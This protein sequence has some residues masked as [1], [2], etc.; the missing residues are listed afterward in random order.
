[1]SARLRLV[2]GRRAARLRLRLDGGVTLACDALDLAETLR[3]R[4]FGYA[5]EQRTAPFVAWLAPRI[6]LYLEPTDD[7]RLAAERL[8]AALLAA[9]LAEEID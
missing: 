2:L 6:D 1:M 3:L 5:G 7:D 9:G 4:A 8:L